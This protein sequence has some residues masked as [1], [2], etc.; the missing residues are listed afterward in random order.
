MQHEVTPQWLSDRDL[1]QRY[2]VSRITIWR[3]SKAGQLP[4]PRKLGGNTTRWYAPDIE[5]HD[6]RVRGAAA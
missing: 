5:A 4:K 3:W 1:A 6:N 2:S